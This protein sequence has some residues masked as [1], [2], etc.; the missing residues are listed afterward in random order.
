MTFTYGL[1]RVAAGRRQLIDL[2]RRALLRRRRPRTPTAPPREGS[3][4][5]RQDPA[6]H[7]ESVRQ[8]RYV[9]AGTSTRDEAKVLAERV[10][11]EVEAGGELVWEAFP[12][13]PFAIFGGMGG[14]GTPI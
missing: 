6:R 9:I 10:H 8:F 12:G 1:A 13:N 14:T 4:N 11:G 7:A 2:Q 3:Q 5:P